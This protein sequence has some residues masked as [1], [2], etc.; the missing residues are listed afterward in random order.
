MD[1][2]MT[3]EIRFEIYQSR[4]IFETFDFEDDLSFLFLLYTS[5]T[6]STSFVNFS[7]KLCEK[8]IKQYLRDEIGDSIIVEGQDCYLMIKN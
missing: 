1:A 7:T 2:S 5:V 6:S 3:S 4:S 8:D